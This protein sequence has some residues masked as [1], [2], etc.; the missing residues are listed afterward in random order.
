MLGFAPISAVAISEVRDIS[1]VVAQA[2]ITSNAVVS[3]A[4]NYVA[5]GSGAIVGRAFVTALEGPIQG[6]AA[7]NS[8][9]VVRAN[10]G[11]I[12]TGDADISASATVTAFGGKIAS[13]SAAITGLATVSAIANNAVLA[14][15]AINSKAT[16]FAN[17]V[18]QYQGNASITVTFNVSALGKIV[19]EEWSKITPEANVWQKVE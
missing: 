19:G 11:Y 5:R 14:G 16:M 6:N 8:R 3:A 4:G 13:G 12:L 15:A 2:Q 1:Y 18:A 10:G 17:P 7:I 9:A